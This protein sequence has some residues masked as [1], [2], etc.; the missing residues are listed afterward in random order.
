[1]R[2]GE[3]RLATWG[4]FDLKEML[5]TIPA[6]RTKQRREHLVPLAPQTLPILESVKTVTYLP[7]VLVFPGLR[8]NRPLSDN[9]LNVALRT[10][11]YD[12]NTHVAHG[13]RS[14]ASTMLNE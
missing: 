10:M 5:W 8:P 2:P 12:G 7:S 6:E 11:G 14:S 3:L 4:E 9:T 1:V 13:F